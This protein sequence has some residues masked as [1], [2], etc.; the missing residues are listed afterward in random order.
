M[1]VIEGFHC[2]CVEPFTVDN[3]EDLQLVA[4]LDRVAV[5]HMNV[6]CATKGA[7]VNL[8]EFHTNSLQGFQ[9]SHISR[10]THIR[11]Y[12]I[13]FMFHRSGRVFFLKIEKKM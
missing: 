11:P 7:A 8:G 2:R 6:L 3:L 1:S 4:K 9:L 10:E 13:D 5:C 12:Q